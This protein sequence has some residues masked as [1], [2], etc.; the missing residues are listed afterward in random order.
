MGGALRVWPGATADGYYYLLA[1]Q[2]ICAVSQSFIDISGPKLG[3]NEWGWKKGSERMKGIEWNW[4]HTTH[5]N[6]HTAA[7]WFPPKERTTATALASGPLF[8]S[9][10]LA[11]A[12]APRIVHKGSRNHPFKFTWTLPLSIPEYIALQGREKDKDKDK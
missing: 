4:N 9:V 3:I 1:G 7:N 2:C 10:L 5:N 11:Y 8:L 6:H 12:A